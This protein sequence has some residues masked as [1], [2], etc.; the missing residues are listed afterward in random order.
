MGP[1][2]A[3][4][5]TPYDKP[6][7]TN[8]APAAGNYLRALADLGAKHTQVNTFKP[9]S[10]EQP[11]ILGTTSFVEKNGR[12]KPRFFWVQAEFDQEL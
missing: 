5:P 6:L 8:A 9:V 12:V 2:G 11:W 1:P 4:G 7:K 3:T 10:T